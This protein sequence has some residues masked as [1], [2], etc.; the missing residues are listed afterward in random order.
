MTILRWH[1]LPFAAASVTSLVALVDLNGSIRIWQPLTWR[2]KVRAV[3]QAIDALHYLHSHPQGCTWH[4][5]FKPANILLDERLTAYLGDTGFAKA[6][7]CSGERSGTTTTVWGGAGSLGF[8][9]DALRP[10][11]VHTEGFA[12][13]VTLL[14]VLTG[15]EPGETKPHH[16]LSLQPCPSCSLLCPCTSTSH[17]WQAALNAVNHATAV[18]PFPTRCRSGHR[19]GVRGCV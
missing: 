6:A 3:L 4:R 1:P 18:P 10:P 9:E 12:V 13:G 16:P 19:G 14:V 2:Q 15:H 8:C 7:Q 17:R 5:D 11:D